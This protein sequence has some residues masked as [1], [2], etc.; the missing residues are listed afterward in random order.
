MILIEQLGAVFALA[1]EDLAATRMHASI[2]SHIVDLALVN[3]PAVIF[4]AVLGHFFSCVKY[5]VW[6]LNQPCL[7]LALCYEV[8]NK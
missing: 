2:L 1:K 3:S 4:G 8:L 6:I 5:C 7:V